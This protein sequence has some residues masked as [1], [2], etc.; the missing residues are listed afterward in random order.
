VSS[1]RS[2]RQIV[3]RTGI[4][5]LFEKLLGCYV[6]AHYHEYPIVD[7]NGQI[8]GHEF[9]TT[10]DHMMTRVLDGA[11]SDGEEPPVLSSETGYG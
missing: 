8:I 9:H 11:Q 5:A 4:P 7:A 2:L 1:P 3:R 6:R 10:R